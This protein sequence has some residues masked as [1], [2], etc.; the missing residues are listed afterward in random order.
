MIIDTEKLV[1]SSIRREKGLED[2]STPMPV[3]VAVSRLFQTESYINFLWK[4]LRGSQI[5]GEFKHCK[6]Y[7]GTYGGQTAFHI[8]WKNNKENFVSYCGH[9]KKYFAGLSSCFIDHKEVEE[10]V[11]ELQ[12]L[13]ENFDFI[14]VEPNPWNE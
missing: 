14:K 9:T 7:T 13:V 1:D 6:F 2:H 4:Q 10:F 3:K 8:V 12:E 11:L 5:R